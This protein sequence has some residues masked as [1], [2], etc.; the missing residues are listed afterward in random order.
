[1][2]LVCRISDI[3]GSAKSEIDPFG[4]PGFHGISEID[5][6]NFPQEARVSCRW[7]YFMQVCHAL[8]VGGLGGDE[9]SDSLGLI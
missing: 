4:I 5:P 3:G 9:S 8:G 1:M 6:C 7:V 2:D